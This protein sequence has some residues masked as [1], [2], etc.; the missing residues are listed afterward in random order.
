VEIMDVLV[1]NLYAIELT[2]E[3]YDY[4]LYTVFLDY[5]EDQAYA[6]GLWTQEWNA[7]QSSSDD[8]VVRSLLERLFSALIETPE[9]QIY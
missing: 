8:T 6:R 2:Q 9:F 7:Y 1:N 4:F 5:P 3:R